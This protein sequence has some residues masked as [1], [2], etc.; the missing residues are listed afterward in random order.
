M[1]KLKPTY[2]LPAFKA[3]AGQMR[4]T[5]TVILDAAALGCGRQEIEETIQTMQRDQFYKSMPSY[6]DHRIWQDVYHVPSP[7]GTLYI[8]FTADAMTEFTL[9]SFKEK[10]R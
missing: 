3:A 8:K 10:G 2:D 6:L 5:K 1:E 9:L 4:M 7:W